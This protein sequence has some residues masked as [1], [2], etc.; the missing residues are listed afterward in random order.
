MSLAGDDRAEL[1]FCAEVMGW[2]LVMRSNPAEEGEF[3]AIALY[4][5]LPGVDMSVDTA[6]MSACATIPCAIF[7][8]SWISLN[9]RFPLRSCSAPAPSTGCRTSSLSAISHARCWSPTPAS[10]A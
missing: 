8:D 3:R 7:L 9:L 1:D 6:R 2:C 10:H 4:C 5:H